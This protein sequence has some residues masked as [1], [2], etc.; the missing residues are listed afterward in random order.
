LGKNTYSINTLGIRLKS[1]IFEKKTPK[2]M[3]LCAGNSL[4]R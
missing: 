1:G 3:W 4:V 2:C